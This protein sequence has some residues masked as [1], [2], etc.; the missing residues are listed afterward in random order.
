MSWKAYHRR[1]D[2]L[3]AVI[4]ASA[5][6]RDGLLP[7]DVDGVAE[8]F[9]DELDL[10]AALQLKWHTRLSGRIEGVLAGQPLDLT[11][12]VALAWS[13]TAEEL[14]GV[15]LVLDR[16]RAE[17]TDEAIA[18]AMEVATGKEHA[19]L[20]VM[21][22]R[23]GLAAPAARRI[24]AEIEERARRLHRG[25]SALDPA[26]AAGRRVGLLERIRAALAA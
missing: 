15:R 1:G 4:A 6:R 23:S 14:A 19:F 5:A 26:P 8:T 20:A 17:P 3:R 13:R 21:A 16:Y 11:E 12:A 10:L 18:H 2:T 7:M 22:G 9:R 24:G 25:V